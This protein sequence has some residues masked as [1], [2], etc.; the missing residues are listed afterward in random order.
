MMEFV[1]LP[2]VRILQE[3]NLTQAEIAQQIALKKFLDHIFH[4]L[5]ILQWE[6][7]A[8]YVFMVILA[9]FFYTWLFISVDLVMFS[10]LSV[11][12]TPD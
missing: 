5:Y 11:L 2:I 7:C 12:T 3:R 10:V 8:A 9:Y 6:L 4:Q 1:P